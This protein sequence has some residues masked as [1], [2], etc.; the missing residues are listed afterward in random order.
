METDELGGSCQVE[1]FDPNL[2]LAN[3]YYQIV[4][5][6]NGLEPPTIDFNRYE[7]TLESAISSLAFQGETVSETVNPNVKAGQQISIEFGDRGVPYVRYEFINDSIS[8]DYN[9]RIITFGGSVASKVMTQYTK[10]TAYSNI[11]FRTLAEQ[12]A[13]KYGLTVDID[14]TGEN[15]NYEYIPQIGLSDYQFILYEAKRLGYRV[16]TSSATLIFKTVK[17]DEENVITLFYGDNLLVANFDYKVETAGSSSVRASVGKPSDSKNYRKFKINEDGLLEPIRREIETVDD[18][19]VTSG[20]SV[21]QIDPISDTNPVS[22]EKENELRVKGLQGSFDILFNPNT[23]LMD[24]YTAIVTDG[25][26][27]VLSRVWIPDSISFTYENNDIRV[28]ATVYSPLKPKYNEILPSTDQLLDSSLIDGTAIPIDPNGKTVNQILIESYQTLGGFSSRSGP[29]GGNVACVWAINK[30]FT[31]GGISPL[32]GGALAVNQARSAFQASPNG[33]QIR[34]GTEQPGDISLCLRSD[35]F[36]GHIGLVTGRNSTV[37]NS[38]SRAAF[39]WRSSLFFPESYG[40][41]VVKEVWRDTR[42]F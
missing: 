41:A 12:I 32:W 30:L 10:N 20:S 14:D 35:G 15:P 37:S 38:S 24:P 11:D 26:G 13:A 23:A 27:D 25:L 5:D 22:S 6:E 29:G 34:V 18:E 39:V 16:T 40:N 31:Q 28:Y 21:N 17:T 2:L 42:T 1:I 8:F 3:E 4:F 7:P 36:Q 33:V 19:S 9:K